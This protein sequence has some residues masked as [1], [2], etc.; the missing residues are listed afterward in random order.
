MESRCF[1]LR[2]LTTQ[3]RISKRFWVENSTKLLYLSIPSS[4]ET[5]KIFTN[6]LRGTLGGTQYRNTVRK[7]GKYRNTTS[8]IVQIPIPHILI[9]FK[10]G[11]LTYGCCHVALLIIPGIY[12]PDFDV[13]VIFSFS[14]IFTE[15]Y[16]RSTSTQQ[17]INSN[18]NDSWKR[19]KQTNQNPFYA[20]LVRV[21]ISGS[22]LARQS[23]TGLTISTVSHAAPVRG[24]QDFTKP[25]LMQSKFA[26]LQS[27]KTNKA[28]HPT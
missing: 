10:I 17:L 3:A 12:A 23:L 11:S 8:K 2:A 7:N 16:I 20:R 18:E 22:S 4:D 9:T 27:I 24:K 19:E 25:G 13:S 21:L 6:M 28:W 26:Q 15:N 14:Q 1:A 5:W